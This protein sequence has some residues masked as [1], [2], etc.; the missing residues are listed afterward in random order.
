DFFQ[1]VGNKE[2]SF[3]VSSGTYFG[4]VLGLAQMVQWMIYPKN[5]TLPVGGAVVGYVTNWIALKW[6]FEPLYPTKVGPFVLQGLFL[7]RQKEVS[8]EFSTYLSEKILNSRGVWNAIMTEPSQQ[9]FAQVI[10]R[11][12]PLMSGARL[13]AVMNRLKGA[14]TVGGGVVTSAAAASGQLLHKYT[15]L[16]LGLRDLLVE[17]M[18]RLSPAE[19]EQVL[20]PIFQDDEMI[21]IV[22]GGVLGFMAGGL[23]WWLNVE[24]DKQ[25]LKKLANAPDLTGA[26]PMPNPTA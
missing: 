3:L 2:L 25:R 20:H 11:N 23:Q 6:I 1:R 19:F 22:A 7:R 10:S 18:N 9:K 12:V 24:I 4:F 14:L 26:M 15:D 5:W 21:L 13:G 17:R 16:K 8:L